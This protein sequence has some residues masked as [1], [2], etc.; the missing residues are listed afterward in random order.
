MGNTERVEDNKRY[1]GFRPGTILLLR[2]GTGGLPE[3]KS[4]YS[5]IALFL[6]YTQRG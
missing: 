1:L 6:Y 2:Q 4:E 5:G 3:R